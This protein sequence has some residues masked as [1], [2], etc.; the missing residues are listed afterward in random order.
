MLAFVLSSFLIKPFSIIAGLGSTTGSI[1]AHAVVAGV[2]GALLCLVEFSPPRA[3]APL[4]LINPTCY[5]GARDAWRRLLRIPEEDVVL[6]RERF[7]PVAATADSQAPV[8]RRTARGRF[9]VFAATR[10]GCTMHALSFTRRNGGGGFHVVF[11]WTLQVK[12]MP[13]QLQ[14]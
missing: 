10:F 1:G 12:S 13:P 8:T 2:A 9:R 6:R 14:R 4:R 5:A 11:D 3:W 7:E